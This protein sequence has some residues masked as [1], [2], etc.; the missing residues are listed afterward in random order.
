VADLSVDASATATTS[1][2]PALTVCVA[3]NPLAQSSFRSSRSIAMI[4]VAPARFRSSADRRRAS[5]EKS[6]ALKLSSKT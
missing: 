2:A 1:A 5:V 6:R 4:F 3:P